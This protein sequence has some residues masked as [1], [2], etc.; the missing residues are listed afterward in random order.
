M[1]EALFSII[2]DII[3][4]NDLN[5]EDLYDN[6]IFE[7]TKVMVLEIYS[8]FVELNSSD[9]INKICDEIH[10]LLYQKQNMPQDPTYSHSELLYLEAKF[11]HLE[12]IPQ[13][14][15]RSPEWHTFR[16]NRLTASDLYSVIDK[17]GSAKRNELIMKKCGAS[18]PFLTNDA[19]LHGIKFEE[20]AVQIYE[21]RNNVIITEFG[22][23]P[24]SIIPFFGAS[25]DGIVHYNSENKNYVGR[26]LEIKCPKSRKITG[27]IP[28][29][30]FA[31]VQGQLEVCDLE[32]CDF[33][34]CDFQ[35]YGSK[36]EFFNDTEP[37]REKGMIIELHDSNLKKTLYYY[38]EEKHIKCRET[39]EKWQDELISNIYDNDNLEYLTTVF[40]Y[41]NK[42]NVVLVKRD[43]NYFTTN[44]AN[45][46]SFWDDVLKYREI[47]IE[48]LKSSNPK[49]VYK[50]KELNFLD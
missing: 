13:P 21:K 20:L 40:W 22:C 47:G 10:K 25:P 34:E 37:F 24:H 14:E 27:I 42:Y 19:I 36:D 28:Q 30:Y 26:M 48:S 15:Q 16:N 31:Q 1:N 12:Q 49:K 8:Q 18:I 44:F 45:I 43:R 9:E 46:K 3:D 5:Y 2:N 7:E 4:N 6:S 33:L 38:S 23:L 17:G 11:K 29:G 50:E 32:Y 41:L 39:F 35:K